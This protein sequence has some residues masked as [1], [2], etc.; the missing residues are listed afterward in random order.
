MLIKRLRII[1]NNICYGPCPAPED[2]VEQHLTITA[3]GRVFFSI[4]AYGLGF[5]KY[6]KICTNYSNIGAA[7]ATRILALIDKY[8]SESPQNCIA[9]DIG[10][11]QME[12]IFCD[13]TVKKAD[14][15]LCFCPVTD[16][17]VITKYIR[18]VLGL[19]GLYLFDGCE[20]EQ[21]SSCI[22]PLCDADITV[23]TCMEVSDH[24]DKQPSTTDL[25]T[26]L[27][28]A[29]EE[30]QTICRSCHFHVI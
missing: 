5:G 23:G 21:D 2:E 7:K 12:M 19:E 26:W 29:K 4:Y 30:Q 8:F 13:G 22:C 28:D 16:G 24:F 1:S 20:E 17:I 3:D 25:P 18:S 6:K 27:D 9:T 15:S 11:W 10:T 14:G